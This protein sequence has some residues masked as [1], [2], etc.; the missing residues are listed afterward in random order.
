MPIFEYRCR[1]CGQTTERIQR[2]PE[3]EIVCPRCGQKAKREVS[4]FSAGP[5]SC[6]PPAGGS[7]FS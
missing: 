7:G 2:T 1:Q 6:T 3:E 4:V 5:G